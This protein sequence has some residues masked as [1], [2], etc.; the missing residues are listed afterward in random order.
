[1][2]PAWAMLVIMAALLGSTHFPTHVCEMMRLKAFADVSKK[3]GK[4][5]VNRESCVH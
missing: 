1:M 5:H 3:Y 2:F 4:E